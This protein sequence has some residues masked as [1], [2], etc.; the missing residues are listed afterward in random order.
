MVSIDRNQWYTV[1]TRL[2][3]ESIASGKTPGEAYKFMQQMGYDETHRNLRKH[4][5]SFRATG[6]AIRVVHGRQNRN[7]RIL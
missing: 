1:F 4:V 5:T 2:Y 7:I 3:L 6:R